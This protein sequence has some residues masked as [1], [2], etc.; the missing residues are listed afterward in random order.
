MRRVADK[1]GDYAG[2]LIRVKNITQD[3]V[4]GGRLII[5][6]KIKGNYIMAI[7]VSVKIEG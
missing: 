7:M 1:D 6:L 2:L 4:S 3:K 5:K